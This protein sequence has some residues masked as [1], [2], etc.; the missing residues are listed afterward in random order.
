MITITTANKH[1]FKKNVTAKFLQAS[2][3]ECSIPV[4]VLIGRITGVEQ[5]RPLR[6]SGTNMAMFVDFGPS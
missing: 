6:E 2:V 3:F 1:K 4:F 5:V